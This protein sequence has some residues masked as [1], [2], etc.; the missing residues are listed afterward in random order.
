M[1]VEVRHVAW[2]SARVL[3]A[4]LTLASSACEKTEKTGTALGCSLGVATAGNEE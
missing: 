3:V 4:R 1:V 2:L